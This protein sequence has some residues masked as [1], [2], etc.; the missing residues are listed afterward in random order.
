MSCAGPGVHYEVLEDTVPLWTTAVDAGEHFEL[1]E[2]LQYA[3]ILL[4][5]F[6]YTTV[7]VTEQIGVAGSRLG[8]SG[9]AMQ[10][11]VSV[12]ALLFGGFLSSARPRRQP[13]RA[14]PDG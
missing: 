7:E 10:W 14:P 12:Y 8:G 13:L 3:A 5:V 1:R 6:G 9:A 4:Q 11:W 2:T